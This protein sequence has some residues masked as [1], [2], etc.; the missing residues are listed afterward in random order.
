M[1]NWVHEPPAVRH[2]TNPRG[3]PGRPASSSTHTTTPAEAAKAVA[4]SADAYQVTPGSWDWS[5]IPGT[6]AH[7]PELPPF[8]PTVWENHDSVLIGVFLLGALYLWAVGPLRRKKGWAPRF[9]VARAV[10]FFSGLLVMVFALNGPLHDLSDYY[11]FSAHMVQH[12]MLTQLMAPLL[13]LG[14]P[15]WLVRAVL[16]RPGLQRAGRFW[17][18]PLVG[19]GVFIAAIVFWH[20]VPFYDLMMRNHN[21]HIG[22]HVL[23]MVTAVMAWW[24]V[25]SPLP[26]AGRAPEPVQMLYLFLLGIPMQIVAAVITLADRPLYPWYSTAPRVFGLSPI[27]D[28]QLGGLYMWIPGGF[29]LWVAITVVW[30]VWARKNE[31]GRG[32]RAGDGAPAGE[33]AGDEEPPLTLPQVS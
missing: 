12:L 9:P 18:S 22:T 5:F 4:G 8:D 27:A 10:T 2:A 6:K 21:V 13:I 28:Q 26:E 31:P 3:E 17:G 32:R 1:S 25:C 30:L 24:S 15:V 23:F 29:A 33:A 16:A 19:G 7:A 14:L 11:Q 20:L